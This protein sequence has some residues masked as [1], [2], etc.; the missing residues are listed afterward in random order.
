M[1]LGSFHRQGHRF[2]E[3]TFPHPC[4]H[5]QPNFF[6]RSKSNILTHTIHVYDYKRAI[7]IGKSDPNFLFWDIKGLH[8]D[9]GFELQF[10]EPAPILYS[11]S[12]IL[13]QHLT[14]YQNAKRDAK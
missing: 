10:R 14:G 6:S 2:S 4:T 3:T 7:L 1:I 5:Y 9:S 12:L 8:I 11:R 13:G